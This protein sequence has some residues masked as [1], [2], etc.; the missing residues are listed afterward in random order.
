VALEAARILLNPLLNKTTT[1]HKLT[2]ELVFQAQIG[3]EG[4]LMQDVINVGF[5]EDA[6]KKIPPSQ[7]PE[8]PR[9]M[10]MPAVAEAL[11]GEDDEEVED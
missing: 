4:Q 5:G 6:T 11:E 1:E 3:R 7:L 8:D 10:G 2:K 9:A